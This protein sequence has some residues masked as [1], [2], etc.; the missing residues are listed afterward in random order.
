MKDENIEQKKREPGNKISR[1]EFLKISAFMG[2][3]AVIASQMPGL[4]KLVRRAEAGTLTAAE[5]YAL[6]LPENI[7][8][9][10]CQQCNTN[11][12]IKVKLLDGVIARIDGNPYSPFTLNPHI[13]YK[14]PLVEA[15]T[16]DGG[17]CPKAHAGIQTTYDPYRI[18][19]VLKR[20]GPRGSNKWKTITFKQAIDEIVEGGKLF[21]D[22]SG[23]ENREVTGLKDLWALRDPEVAKAM[24]GDVKAILD[25]KDKD[26]KKGLV[27]EFKKKHKDHLDMLMDPDHPDLGPKNNQILYV[28]GRQKAG[29]AEFIHRFFGDNLGSTNRHGHTTVCQGSLYFTGK[30]M[31]EQWD[32]HKF[33]GGEKFYWQADVENSE[34]VIFVGASPFEANYGPTN[35]V[36]RITSGL[37]TGRLKYVVVD[38]RL[39]KAAAKAWKWLPAKPGTEAALALALIRTVFEKERYDTRFLENAN[40]AAAAKDKEPSWTNASWLVKIEEDKPSK[41]LRASDLNMVEKRE[42]E[43]DDKK[44]TEYV[45]LDDKTVFTFDPFVVRRNGEYIIFNPN[46]D[47]NVVEGDI[48]VDLMVSG[49]RVKSGLQI[50]HDSAFS[51][52]LEEWAK[53]CDVGVNDLVEIAEE[54]TS[55]GKKAAVD[56]HR[57]VSQHTNGFYNVYAWF[58]LAALIGNYDWKGGQVKLSAYDL[59]GKKAEGPF[60]F[61]KMNPGALAPF[62]IS[63]I[64][65]DVKY[66]ATTIFADYPAKRNWYPLASDIYQEIFTSSSDAYPYSI[67]AAFLYMGSP[68]YS[69]PAGNTNID[70]LSDVNKLPLFVTWDIVIGETSMYADYIFPDLSNLERWEFSGSHPSMTVKLQGV[71]QPTIAPLIETVTVFG[72]QM[73][74]S[75]EST[76]LAMAES[77]NLPGFGPDGFGDGVPF[78]HMDDMYLRIV[79][80]LA[81]GEKSDGSDAV[82][83]ADDEEVKLFMDSRKHLPKSVF[84]PARWK[85]IVGD[86]L[87]RK[88]I[89]VLN[90]GGRFQEYSKIFSGDQVT[91]KYGKLINIYQEKT[92]GVKSSMTGKAIPGFPT[93]IPAPLDVTGE[94]IEDEKAGF[95]LNLITFREVSQ[96]KSRT[97]SNY[98]L[99]ALLPENTIIMN[100]MDAARLG[101]KHGDLARITSATNLDGIWDLK[102]GSKVPI[103]GKVRVI[104]G[105]RPGVVGFSLGH[106]HW[107]YGG[108]D[109]M[110]DGQVVKGDP[111]RVRGIHANAAMR[112]DPY[113]K[114][115]CLS[116]PVGGSAVFYDTRVKVIKVGILS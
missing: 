71:R 7:I 79:A 105:M 109:V 101:F 57:G 58:S 43:K 15:A 48:F 10:V 8:Y 20:N 115:T 67:K 68:V 9:S 81:F 98:W 53:I 97:T 104:Q 96:T 82:P 24:A 39:S 102:N 25:E 61:S 100:E 106:G 52:T 56:V 116:D 26:K 59:V 14:A 16:V 90:R 33:S 69:L 64:R 89:Y 83:D 46:D 92:A 35:R 73:P 93:Y 75:L 76:L 80:N 94:P 19:K 42:V 32:G 37:S 99:S 49:I 78:T 17:V 60:D 29:R 11:C 77:L 103:I 23:E 1:R 85:S 41:F 113:L 74:I 40:K 18:V 36:P 5:V 91:N 30:A 72:Q 47:K 44:E 86:E 38:P 27:E 63:V 28:S 62:G 12:G 112:I 2:G 87:W 66:E 34:F 50:L 22:V 51:K 6:S 108:V 111:R 31:S 107:A 88:V 84:D 45:T 110:I 55:H 3:S 54:F 95:D 4:W 21:S 13:S 70:I 114:N 65:H